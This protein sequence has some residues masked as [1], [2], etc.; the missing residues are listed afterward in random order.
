MFSNFLTTEQVAAIIGVKA[1]RVR[2]LAL[3]G[4][5]KALRPEGSR[6]WRFTRQAV[7]DYMGVKKEDI[8]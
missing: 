3:A 2:E 1:D 4:I 7:A 6:R 5:I 8:L